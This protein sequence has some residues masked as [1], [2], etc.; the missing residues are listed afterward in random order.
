MMTS[1]HYQ[2]VQQQYHHLLR[3]ILLTWWDNCPTRLAKLKDYWTI[4]IASRRISCQKYYLAWYVSNLSEEMDWFHNA[5]TVASLAKPVFANGLKHRRRVHL[6]VLH[7]TWALPCHFRACYHCFLWLM[8]RLN[9]WAVCGIADPGMTLTVY[10][11]SLYTCSS[12]LFILIT[13]QSTIIIYYYH[14]SI[15]IYYTPQYYSVDQ[16]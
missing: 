16:C 13:Q 9:Y 14:H 15:H 4:M 3:L 11:I 10:S 6:V 7:V 8:N 12:A 2:N 5:V 1:C